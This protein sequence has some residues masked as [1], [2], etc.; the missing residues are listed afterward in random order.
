M[1]TYSIL[2]TFYVKDIEAYEKLK[3][4]LNSN[5]YVQKRTFSLIKSQKKLKNFVFSKDKI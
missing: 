3:K 2:K 1:S 5:K 4:E